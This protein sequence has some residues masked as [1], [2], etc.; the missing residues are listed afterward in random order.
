MSHP[1]EIMYELN[2]QMDLLQSLLCGTGLETQEKGMYW[3]DFVELVQIS[4]SL[5][6]PLSFTVMMYSI[7]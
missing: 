4:W 6:P 7:A 1:K 5:P 3:P 2:Q